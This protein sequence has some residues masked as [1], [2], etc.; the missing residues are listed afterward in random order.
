MN[1]RHNL[2]ALAATIAV[3]GAPLPA[4][5]SPALTIGSKAPAIKVDRWYK[6]Q[7]LTAFQPGGIHVVEFWATW[8]GP[9]KKAIPHLSELAATYKGKVTFTG[10][11]VF[12]EGEKIPA[13]IKKFVT[14]MGDKMKYSVAGDTADGTMAKTWVEA[15]G[16]N[17]IPLTFV[18]E[19]TGRIA[20]IGHPSEVEGPIKQL[21]AGTYNLEAEAQARKTFKEGTTLA[22]KLEKGIQDALEAKDFTLT[23]TRLREALA[24][25]HPNKMVLVGN[26]ATELFH[27][28]EARAGSE[29]SALAASRDGEIVMGAMACLLDTD[30]LSPRIYEMGLV[31][32]EKQIAAR[33]KEGFL[34]HLKAAGH[35]RLGNPL[36]AKECEEKALALLK[37]DP[38]GSEEDAQSFK[39][40][41]AQYRKALKTA[42]P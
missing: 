39:D 13:R 24:S 26:V 37:E 41:L 5:E 23:M 20:W 29:F 3:M 36:K 19:G 32:I 10:I 22:E 12:E 17:G 40:A 7:P 11:S 16:E 35:F 28:D 31:D 1:L 4:A 25:A 8:C 27:L 33:P 14:G 15:A 21:L 34:W 2:C 9:C 6:G 38:E 30:R 42:K 18:V